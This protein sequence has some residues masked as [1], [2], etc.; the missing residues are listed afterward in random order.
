MQPQF[1]ILHTTARPAAWRKAY[2]AWVA[3][4]DDPRSIEY[5]LC[6]DER[7]KFGSS[8]DFPD[9]GVMHTLCHNRGRKSFVSGVNTAAAMSQ[10]RI[11]VA[12]ADDLFPCEHWD[13]KLLERIAR[14]RLAEFAI[15]V[16]TGTPREHERGLAIIQIL[17]RTR[18]ERFGFVMYPE[19]ESMYSD[20]DFYEQAVFDRVL[21]D[22][23]DLLFPHRHF[24]ITG[25]SPDAVYLHENRQPAYDLG[26][27]VLTRRRAQRSAIAGNPERAVPQASIELRP[28]LMAVCT[29]GETFSA[30]W[31]EAFL[32]LGV[33]L[34]EMGI[35]CKRYV[36]HTSNVYRTRQNITE[37]V[38][39]DANNSG[40]RPDLVLW[41]D[42]DN[43]LLPEQL[44]GLVK[45][46]QRYPDVD[47]VAGWCWIHKAHGWATSV[48]QFWP[49]DGVSIAPLTL[50]DLFA[51]KTVAERAGAKIIEHTGFPC[52]LMRYSALEKLGAAAFRPLTK[53]DLPAIFGETR[54]A[55]E[56]P[57]D[58]YCGEDTAW[59]LKAKQAGLRMVVDP[60]C[61]VAHLKLQV[62]EPD[63]V[64]DLGVPD[65]PELRDRRRQ[66]ND[67]PVV[68]YQAM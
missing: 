55:V 41:L 54:P 7:W 57:D 65:S 34:G 47:V 35:A 68:E 9:D 45:F 27:V 59:C 28:P 8:V 4:C 49:E 26:K 33:K 67:A 22:A 17:S 15:E 25:E 48:G 46:L 62:Q 44:E 60:G 19:F 14:S 21:I 66:L 32:N 11:L 23:R 38:V 64:K 51:G 24:S 56:R 58:W 31:L 42:D 12:N 1:S 30:M 5:V 16:T 6:I 43:V 18:Y 61:K 20:N 50:A 40:E 63:L 52:V 37:R 36:G 10:G 13:T 53:A 3:A 39:E 2:D 29:P